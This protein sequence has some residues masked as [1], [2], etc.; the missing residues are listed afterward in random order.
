MSGSYYIVIDPTDNAPFKVKDV[1]DKTFS[2]LRPLVEMTPVGV[3]MEFKC[4]ELKS[5]KKGQVRNTIAES[6]MKKLD[7][8]SQHLVYGSVVL[9]DKMWKFLSTEQLNRIL[10]AYNEQ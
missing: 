7:M 2:Q 9:I 8:D 10:V 1:N 6:L 5:K 4:Y 3:N